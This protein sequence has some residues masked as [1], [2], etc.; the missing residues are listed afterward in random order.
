M[1]ITDERTGEVFDYS[2][3]RGL[4]FATLMMPGGQPV[5]RD[6]FWNLVEHHHKRGDAQVARELIAAL[7]FELNDEQRAALAM[8]FSAEISWRY[9]VAIDLCLHAPGR[10]DDRNEHAHILMSA[11]SVATDGK[12]GK[13]VQE[14]DPIWCKRNKHPTLVDWAR[15]RWEELCN[16]ALERAGHSTRIDHRSHEARGLSDLPTVKQGNGPKRQQR[17]TQNAEIRHINA[18]LPAL[19]KARAKARAAE[20][21][22]RF[23][24]TIPPP[25]KDV[26]M[27]PELTQ[28]IT[29][30]VDALLA[31]PGTTLGTLRV[32]LWPLGV[33]MLEDRHDDFYWKVNNQYLPEIELGQQYTRS[34]LLDRGLLLEEPKK[35]LGFATQVEKHKPDQQ[36][37]DD[38]AN[39]LRTLLDLSRLLSAGAQNLLIQFLNFVLNLLGIDYQIQLRQAEIS[40]HTHAQIVGTGMG[41]PER[42]KDALDG[43]VEL[44]KKVQLV[45]NPDLNKA[46]L[47]R[48]IQ[49]LEQ[50]RAEEQKALA[51]KVNSS[52]ANKEGPE[53]IHEKFKERRVR[54]QEEVAELQQGELPQEQRE[55]AL[56]EHLG[57]L[58]EGLIDDIQDQHVTH[59]HKH[60]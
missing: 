16:S 22:S 42:K 14:L 12:L 32:E 41:A 40:Q 48:A 9:Q 54:L 53:R 25:R 21:A 37:D 4:R 6:E 31:Q 27:A 33:T 11:C 2:K 20:L 18:T 60:K 49:E 28:K 51:V 3:K 35:P 7:P 59:G 29:A 44:T 58:R 5:E 57:E 19:K 26:P 50:V 55:Q 46:R 13:K 39:A 8:E 10:G 34:A 30:R 38:L 43:V 1:H 23:I 36:V 15:S 56:N 45:V 17:M 52:W 24:K 47:A